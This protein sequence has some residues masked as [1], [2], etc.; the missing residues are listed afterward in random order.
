MS[1]VLTLLGEVRWRGEPVVGERPQALLAA[2]SRGRAVSAEQ[3]VAEVWRDDV[4]A[5]AAKALQVLV[6]RTR[7]TCGPDA[8]VRAGDGYRL[9]LSP[10]EVDSLVLRS[11]AEA[12]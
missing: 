7:S 10:E 11:R 12:A 5:N 8:V 6:S 1:I 3:L 9:G 4:P 2:L